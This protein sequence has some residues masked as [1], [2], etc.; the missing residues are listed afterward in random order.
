MDVN[1]DLWQYLVA[2]YSGG[3]DL[4]SLLDRR[5][6]ALTGEGTARVQAIIAAAVA[7]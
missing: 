3:S 7:A 1:S 6:E 4:T 5:I 2:L